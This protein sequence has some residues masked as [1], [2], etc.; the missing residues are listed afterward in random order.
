MNIEQWLEQYGYLAVFCGVFLEGPCTL[1]LAGFLAHQGYLN[2]IGVFLTAFIATFMVVELL[3]FI[4]LL[5]GRYLLEKWP[6]WRRNYLRFSTLLERHKTLF[7]ISFRFIYG[8]QVMAATASGMGRIRPGLFS[9][10]NAAG[11]AL[12]TIV[13]LSAGY[14]F[15]HVIE[16][17][18]EEIKLYEKPF[19]F[20]LVAIVLVYYL[21]RRLV[22]R[23][24]AGDKLESP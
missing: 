22:W 8:S 3:Y 16:M 20:V 6:L 2:V 7:I 10:L 1:T 21:V 18:I 12:W 17:L 13:I 11:A 15:G 5:A 24:V 14:F 9:A 19:L 23:R 4:G